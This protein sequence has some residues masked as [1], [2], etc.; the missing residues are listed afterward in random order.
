MAK[1]SGITT[2]VTVDTIADAPTDI[3]NC[4]TSISLNTSRGLQEITGLDMEAV[5]R[6]VLRADGTG[7][8]SGVFDPVSHAV[9]KEIPAAT[10]VPRDMV[11]EYPGATMTLIVLL[12]DYS[13]SM[14][15]DGALTW[16]VPFMLQ[17]GTVPAWT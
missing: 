8:M 13:V 4:I 12:T 9:F 14:G 15:D 3:S 11:I 2:T 17:D 1:V 6:I 16:T 7:S 5:E 10:N